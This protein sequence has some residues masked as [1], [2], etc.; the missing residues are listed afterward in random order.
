[1]KINKGMTLVEVMVALLILSIAM[2]GGISFFINSFN[3]TRAA[4]DLTIR[5]DHALRYIENSRLRTKDVFDRG[6]FG[7]GTPGTFTVFLLDTD[8]NNTFS[9]EPYVM[10][11]FFDETYTIPAIVSFN[12]T[13]G[14][15]VA[16]INHQNNA[17]NKNILA[18]LLFVPNAN[19]L[20]INIQYN[21]LDFESA[22]QLKNSL[23]SYTV[24]F[25]SNALVE[26]INNSFYITEIKGTIC[27]FIV[28][29]IKKTSS[30]IF[31]GVG[32]MNYGTLEDPNFDTISIN[33][34]YNGTIT[35]QNKNVDCGVSLDCPSGLIVRY[36]IC[37]ILEGKI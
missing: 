28:D 18:S 31:T 36:M 29:S 13:V 35:C 3:I 10:E 19:E 15:N 21:N 7:T 33:G 8:T 9:R 11:S 25:N 14:G 27:G 24:N 26:G 22:E 2:I 30:G 32:K 34:L 16:N 17:N 6:I 4:D 23:T 5:M 37:N 20:D 12:T 1:M